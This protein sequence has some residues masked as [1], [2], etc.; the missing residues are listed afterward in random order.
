MLSPWRCP[1]PHNEYTMSRVVVYYE[2]GGWIPIT[3]NSLGQAIALHRRAMQE[4]REI[5]VFP[6]EV[7]PNDFQHFLHSTGW[8]QRAQTKIVSLSSRNEP[9]TA[10]G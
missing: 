3:F 2:S 7:N 1:L 6:P 4:A 8:H 9:L 5:L 10:V